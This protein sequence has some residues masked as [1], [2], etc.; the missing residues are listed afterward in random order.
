[1]NSL[2]KFS[3]KEIKMFQELDCE[4]FLQ[5]DDPAT[6]YRLAVEK[7]FCKDLQGHAVESL[8]RCYNALRDCS[9]Y[10]DTP[11][12]DDMIILTKK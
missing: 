3:Q 6:I 5:L 9:I 11:E 4:N 8:R 1:M 12:W 10:R 7:V 2:T